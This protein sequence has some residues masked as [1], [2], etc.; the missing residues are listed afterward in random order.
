MQEYEWVDSERNP[1]PGIAEYVQRILDESVEG[2]KPGYEDIGM[3]LY[4]AVENQGYPVEQVLDGFM[5]SSYVV[6]TEDGFQLRGE[7]ERDRTISTNINQIK[8]RKTVEGGLVK[9]VE[10]AG[11]YYSPKLDAT[12]TVLGNDEFSDKAWDYFTDS[13]TS[14]E[15]EEVDDIIRQVVF[16]SNYEPIHEARE[17]SKGFQTFLDTQR[18]LLRDTFDSET[19][20]LLRGVGP[21]Y[22]LSRSPEFDYREPP[23]DSRERFFRMEDED[24]ERVME[25]VQD[26]TTVLDRDEVDSWTSNPSS[27]LKFATNGDEDA[28]FVLRNNAG[29]EEIAHSTLMYPEDLSEHEFS[30]F[31]LKQEFE[32]KQF[33]VKEGAGD[34]HVNEEDWVWIYKNLP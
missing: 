17:S 12:T 10:D 29:L 4:E 22:I 28:G 19:V 23:K 27:A 31:N 25:H 11:T 33:S 16:R 1:E 14:Q 32:P 15:E 26:G 18:E 6:E 5:N 3:A 20:P 13:V 21:K 7:D 24:V 2:E 8:L 30:L 9:L 34:K